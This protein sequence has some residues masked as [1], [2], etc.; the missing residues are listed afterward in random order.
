MCSQIKFTPC[1]KVWGANA[2]CAWVHTTGVEPGKCTNW[3]CL[4]WRMCFSC[5]VAHRRTRHQAARRPA[6]R[7]ACHRP[8]VRPTACQSDRMSVALSVCMSGFLPSYRPSV[9]PP[10][11]RS[12]PTP[13]RRSPR[14]SFSHH[15]HHHAAEDPCAPRAVT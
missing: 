6:E 8:S 13:R 1:F 11:F 3:F 7:R 2:L 12:R 9:R 15:H 14:G 5:P 4:L 10:C